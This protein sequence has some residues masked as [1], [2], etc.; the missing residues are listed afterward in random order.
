MFSLLFAYIN[1]IEAFYRLQIWV[2]SKLYILS[3]IGIDISILH[4]VISSKQFHY[5][6]FCNY[7]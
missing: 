6:F 4:C 1:I 2:I 7:S 5:L 3:I